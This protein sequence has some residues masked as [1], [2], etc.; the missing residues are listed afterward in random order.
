[1]TSTTHFK[2]M[3]LFTAIAAAV[4]IGGSLIA[5]AT[6]ASA[7]YYSGTSTTI[8]GTTFHNGYGSGGSY[9]GTTTRIGGTTFH[10]YSTPSGNYYGTTNSIGGTTFHNGSWY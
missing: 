4:V 2:S 9:S 7:Q 6:P 5:T 1:M 8:V 3:K 10:N